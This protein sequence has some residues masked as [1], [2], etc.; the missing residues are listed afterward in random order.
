MSRRGVAPGRRLFEVGAERGRVPGMARDGV[1]GRARFRW[2]SEVGVDVVVR[3]RA[4]LVRAGDAV[5]A[6]APFGS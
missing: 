1:R 2:A 6:E 4:V 3:D 5:D